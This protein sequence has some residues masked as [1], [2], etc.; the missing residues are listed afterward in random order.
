MM[1]GTVTFSGIAQYQP[2]ALDLTTSLQNSIN[3][4]ILDAGYDMSVKVTL[5]SAEIG[6]SASPYDGLTRSPAPDANAGK[7]Y[8][9][10][11]SPSSRQFRL[12]ID[13]AIKPD[14]S[15]SR[16]ALSTPAVKYTYDPGAPQVSIDRDT[17]VNLRWRD[18]AFQELG[19]TASPTAFD[20]TNDPTINTSPRTPITTD[21]IEFTLH[22]TA[23][24]S[25]LPR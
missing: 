21:K 1:T 10:A 8:I 3:Q 25:W 20:Y 17:N 2:T 7:I 22:R 15:S 5:V 16:W 13:P 24:R 14:P 9:T 18:G 19:L 6:Q 12:L 11:T 4:A 23:G